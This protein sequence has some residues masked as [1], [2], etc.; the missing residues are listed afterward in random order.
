MGCPKEIV[1]KI[2]KKDGHYY[3]LVKEKKKN[4][5]VDIK[6]CFSFVLNDNLDILLLIKIMEG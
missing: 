1:K 2:V 6:D 5:Y 4:F 3:F